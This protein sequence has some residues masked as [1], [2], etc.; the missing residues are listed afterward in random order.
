MLWMR[1]PLVVTVV[2]ALFWYLG[3]EE[4]EAQTKNKKKV[5]DAPREGAVTSVKT[6]RDPNPVARNVDRLIEERL[7]ADKIPASPL[8]DDAEFIRRLSLDVRGRVPSGERV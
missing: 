7:A 8:A 1:K 4:V 5:A 3:D 6:T 2:L